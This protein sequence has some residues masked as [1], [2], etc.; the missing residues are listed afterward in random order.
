MKQNK[1]TQPLHIGQLIRAKLETAGM[2]KSCFAR[3][4]GTTAQNVYGIFKRKSCDTELLKT[5]GQVLNFDFFSYYQDGF[6]GTISAGEMEKE[7][8]QLRQENAMLKSHNALLDELN[9]LRKSRI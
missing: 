4:I 3:R 5:I 1:K 8:K 7:L 9:N 2:T 6:S